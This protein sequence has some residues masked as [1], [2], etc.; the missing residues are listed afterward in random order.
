MVREVPFHVTADAETKLVPV[1]VMVVAALPA[2]TEAGEIAV[3]VGT[4]FVMLK[5]TAAEA[6][7]PGAGFV[8][9]TEAVPAVASRLAG[10]LALSA[11]AP[12]YVVASDEPFHMTAEVERKLLPDRVTVVSPLP[13]C[14]ELGVSEVSAGT[15]LLGGGTVFV[16]PPQPRRASE[17]KTREEKKDLH[18]LADIA[19]IC[20]LSYAMGSNK[21]ALNIHSA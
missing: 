5:G 7:P 19:H 14:A 8:T 10:I 6:P 1:S 18:V 21:K 11:V 13:T 2:V 15:G 17:R 20:N 9:V 16:P 4:G 12:L 3:S